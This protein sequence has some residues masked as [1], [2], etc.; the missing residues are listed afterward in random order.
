M[1]LRV[2]RQ[3]PF[4]GLSR[5]GIRLTD[6]SAGAGA[7]RE[8]MGD[9]RRLRSFLFFYYSTVKNGRFVSKQ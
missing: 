1:T 5:Q 2:Y 8:G 3:D 9:E 6:W 7:T 4:I